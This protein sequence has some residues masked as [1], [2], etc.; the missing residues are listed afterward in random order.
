MLAGGRRSADP[1]ELLTSQFPALL[2]RLEQEYEAVVIDPLRSSRSA[3]PASSRATP[4]RRCSSRGRLRPRR[5]VRAA[6]ERLELISVTPTAVVLNYS[7]AVRPSNYYIQPRDETDGD[8]AVSARRL[9]KKR[10]ARRLR[11]PCWALRV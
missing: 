10:G 9:S 5:H 8:K 1:G 4:T 7:V 6:V 3:T 11:R 2:A